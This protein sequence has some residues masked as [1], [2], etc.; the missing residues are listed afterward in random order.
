MSTYIKSTVSI[1][2]DKNINLQLYFMVDRKLII[3]VKYTVG[4][5]LITN[6]SYSDT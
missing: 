3:H 2:V 1:T 4:K 6:L 5:I